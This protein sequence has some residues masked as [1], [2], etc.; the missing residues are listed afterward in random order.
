MFCCLTKILYFIF[1]KFEI[2]TEI[3]IFVSANWPTNNIFLIVFKSG[4]I[5]SESQAKTIKVLDHLSFNSFLFLK[6]KIQGIKTNTL[7]LILQVFYFLV[8]CCIIIFP[9]IWNIFSGIFTWIFFSPESHLWTSKK[10]IYIYH[11]F[12]KW[13]VGCPESQARVSGHVRF[14]PSCSFQNSSLLENVMW[15]V[16]LCNGKC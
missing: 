3:S 16:G 8:S 1:V 9:D 6:D 7:L 14:M 5:M 4:L 12:P 11:A 2:L 13:L 15:R 10:S